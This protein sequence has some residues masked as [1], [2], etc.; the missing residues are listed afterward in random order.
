MERDKTETEVH[1]FA[2]A[3]NTARSIQ[4]KA[5]DAYTLENSTYVAPG[6]LPLQQFSS[7][8]KIRSLVHQDLSSNNNDH[9]S[10]DFSLPGFG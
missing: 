4:L 7:M 5:F 6:P 2:R 3:M 10:F 9:Q 1:L 8:T